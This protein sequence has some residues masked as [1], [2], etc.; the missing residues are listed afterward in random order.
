[1]SLSSTTNSADTVECSQAKSSPWQDAQGWGLP[2]Q[3]FRTSDSLA[4]QLN[5]EDQIA[6]I[7]LSWNRWAQ[8]RPCPVTPTALRRAC[9]VCFQRTRWGTLI[10]STPWTASKMQQMRFGPWISS[11]KKNS[12]FTWHLSQN[13]VIL[14]LICINTP[15]ITSLLPVIIVKMDHY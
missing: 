2:T 14:S 15:V 3:V 7:K 6:Q 8:V 11:R 4:S 9:H 12:P 13:G 10:S 5:P 1:M